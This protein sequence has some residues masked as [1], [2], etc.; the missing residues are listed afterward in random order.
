MQHYLVGLPGSQQRSE[1]KPGRGGG[2]S[3]PQVTVTL[4]SRLFLLLS[5][6]ECHTDVHGASSSSAYL[7]GLSACGLG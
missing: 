1:N 3:G 2:P 4:S 6:A 5:D 7:L